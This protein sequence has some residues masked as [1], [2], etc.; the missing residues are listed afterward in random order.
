MALPTYSSR[1][2][3]VAWSGV[4]LSGLAPDSFV[5]F[6]RTGPITDTESGADGQVSISY[7]P[8]ETGTCTI[9][10]Q[11]NGSANWILSGVLAAQE[12]ARVPIIGS[13]TVTDPSGSVIAIMTNCHIQESPEISLGSTATGNSFSWTFFCERIRFLS[14]PEP[15]PGL[16]DDAARILGAIDTIVNSVI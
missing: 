9:Q 6:S 11:Q 5:T 10:T 14:S 4:N 12:E 3:A 8:D 15:V 13:L 1:R 7:L 2:V 16:E